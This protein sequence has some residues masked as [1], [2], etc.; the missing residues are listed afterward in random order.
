MATTTDGSPFWMSQVRSASSMRKFHC[1]SKARSLGLK[2]ACT[3]PLSST[4]STSGAEPSRR[5]ASPVVKPASRFTR[6]RLRERAA[7]HAR[8]AGLARDPRDVPL[9][10]LRAELHDD[11]R[12]ALARAW[13]VRSGGRTEAMRKLSRACTGRN[14]GTAKPSTAIAV[15][16]REV[17]VME[18][19]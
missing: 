10:G 18:R 5:M 14:I 6:Y 12:L 17:I 13:R 9:L 19:V 4:Y 16:R 2:N 3:G 15:A 8:R 1:T 11:L 7:P